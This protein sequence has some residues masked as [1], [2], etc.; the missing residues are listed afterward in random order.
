MTQ[1]DLCMY[2]TLEH[3]GYRENKMFTGF[4]KNEICFLYILV[5]EHKQDGR[6]KYTFN[7]PSILVQ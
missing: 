3:P 1:A 4:A 5:A 6:L 7:L 2:Y